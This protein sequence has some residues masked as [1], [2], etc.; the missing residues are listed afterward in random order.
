MIYLPPDQLLDNTQY[1]QIVPKTSHLGDSNMYRITHF[2]RVPSSDGW[3]HVLYFR[4]IGSA[5][6][7]SS[8]NNK[9]GGYVYIL[10]NIVYPNL[11]KI[12][13]TTSSSEYRLRKINGAGVVDDWDIAYDFYCLRPWDLEQAVHLQLD[14][15]RFRNDREF[16]ELGV[17]TA[18]QTIEELGK[19]YGPLEGMEGVYTD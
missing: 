1:T 18:I 2:T 16:F 11:I 10:T 19:N 6:E 5:L 8:P 12:G 3:D 13:M 4:Y 9:N 7:N 15:F 17:S 14:K